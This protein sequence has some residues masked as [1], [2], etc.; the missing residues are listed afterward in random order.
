MLIWKNSLSTT[1]GKY[2]KN[3]EVELLPLAWF[4]LKYHCQVLLLKG[5]TQEEFDEKH[6]EYQLKSGRNEQSARGRKEQS[7]GVAFTDW[8]YTSFCPF[9]HRLSHGKRGWQQQAEVIIV[10]GLLISVAFKMINPFR[11]LSQ[12]TSHF[13]TG[14]GGVTHFWIGRLALSRLLSVHSDIGDVT[15]VFVIDCAD[16]AL[17]EWSE[18]IR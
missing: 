13:H 18:T 3:T 5:W 17:P 8:L 7:L 16:H 11:E 6:P 14:P 15:A 10:R 4:R 2:F 9:D 1:E 12:S